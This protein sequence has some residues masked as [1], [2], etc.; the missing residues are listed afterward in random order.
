MA[1]DAMQILDEQ[2]NRNADFNYTFSFITF[3][4]NEGFQ[5]MA[6]SLTFIV[7]FIYHAAA[8]AAI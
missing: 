5:Q 1:K 7:I 2:R 3:V 6:R 8:A 4:L